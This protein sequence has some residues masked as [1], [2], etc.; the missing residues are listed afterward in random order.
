MQSREISPLIY[1]FEV[2]AFH[3]R[4]S[5]Y[6]VCD[7]RV[8]FIIANQDVALQR[9]AARAVEERAACI[10]CGSLTIASPTGDERRGTITGLRC[11]VR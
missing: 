9:A 11:Q 3:S 1:C 7:G 8:I 2:D 10:V 6:E 5:F 4:G